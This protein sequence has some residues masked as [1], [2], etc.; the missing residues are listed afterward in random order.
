M[1]IRDVCTRSQTT[2]MFNPAAY[3]C[4][5]ARRGLVL[6]RL[7]AAL[8]KKCPRSAA[9]HHRVSSTE[10]PLQ[11]E[12]TESLAACKVDKHAKLTASRKPQQIFI[13]CVACL[14]RCDEVMLTRVGSRVDIIDVLLK[15]PQEQGRRPCSVSLNVV[16]G[17]KFVAPCTGPA[18][19]DMQS[20]A[21]RRPAKRPAKGYY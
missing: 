15:S 6:I 8:S 4:L 19:P 2:Y 5:Q 20:D 11:L 14:G 1:R 12:T 16:R 17:T 9:P 7:F 3:S 13:V 18:R 21:G 10:R